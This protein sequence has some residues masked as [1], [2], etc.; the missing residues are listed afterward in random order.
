MTDFVLSPEARQDLFN[1]WEYIAQDNID[2]A[3]RVAGEIRN[4]MATLAQNPGV[5]HYRKDLAD[6][7]LRFWRVY[8]YLIIYRS[9][10]KPIEIVRVLSA[11]R[12]IRKL[13]D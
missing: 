4:A 1:I 12:D 3:D 10:S 2:A 9:E 8:T 5:G 13:L 7:P 11:Y 6:E